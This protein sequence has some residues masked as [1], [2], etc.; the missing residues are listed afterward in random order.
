LDG[1]SLREYGQC[2][3]VKSGNIVFLGATSYS[4]FQTLLPEDVSFS[5]NAQRHRQSDRG[6]KLGLQVDTNNN[7]QRIT[8]I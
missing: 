5:H 4:L 7:P 6:Y 3:G 8:N 1:G 2:R